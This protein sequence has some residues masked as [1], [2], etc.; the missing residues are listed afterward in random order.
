MILSPIREALQNTK[1][2]RQQPNKG[3]SLHMLDSLHD[4]DKA[5]QCIFR[6][7]LCFDDE[8]VESD[9]ENGSYIKFV[10]EGNASPGSACKGL[11]GAA[12]LLVR[13][14]L[15]FARQ[16]DGHHFSL[17]TNLTLLGYILKAIPEHTTGRSQGQKGECA[18]T[19]ARRQGWRDGYRVSVFT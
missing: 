18:G 4:E 12:R 1:L 8:N 14:I 13:L 7:K 10:L 5:T 6:G 2:L 15:C 3:D 16:V 11:G 9:F 19:Q 17:G